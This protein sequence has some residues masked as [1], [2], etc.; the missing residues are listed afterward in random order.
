[1]MYKRRKYKRAYAPYFYGIR[2]IG[3]VWHGH[4]A[5]PELV[6]H[7]HSFDYYD[8]ETPLWECYASQCEEEGLEAT[9]EAFPAWVRENAWRARDYLQNLLDFKNFY[10]EYEDDVA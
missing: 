8:V 1:M 10:D 5:D 6:W 9:D 7:G 3:Y 2:G 4:W